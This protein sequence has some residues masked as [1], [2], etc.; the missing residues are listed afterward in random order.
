[1]TSYGTLNLFVRLG[2]PFLL[3]SIFEFEILHENLVV[4]VTFP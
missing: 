2:L 1:M 3:I 4:S